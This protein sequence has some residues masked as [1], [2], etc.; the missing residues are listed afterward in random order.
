M[1]AIRLAELRQESINHIAK[2]TTQ[3]AKKLINQINYA[4]AT[5]KST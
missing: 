2:I 4:E 5:L 3:N 1:V